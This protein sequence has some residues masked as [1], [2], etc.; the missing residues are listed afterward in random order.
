MLVLS[1]QRDETI[2]MDFR[3]A[4]DEELLSLRGQ[5]IEHVTVDIR[6]DKVRHGFNAPDF[7]TI[8]RKE[9]VDRIERE[10]R[11]AVQVKPEDVQQQ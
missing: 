2:V 8:H 9:I 4:S 5:K 1:R 10:N 11:A 7:V 6:G 3:N